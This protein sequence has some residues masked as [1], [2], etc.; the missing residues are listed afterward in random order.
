MVIMHSMMTLV[1]SNMW[2]AVCLC[3]SAA[4][5]A[6]AGTEQ[7]TP[8]SARQAGAQRAGSFSLTVG[9]VAPQPVCGWHAIDVAGKA[10][11]S[12]QHPLPASPTA[13]AVPCQAHRS[14]QTGATAGPGWIQ[15]S[16]SA[17]PLAQP[18]PTAGQRRKRARW[19]S[20]SHLWHLQVVPI[21][22]WAVQ[23]SPLHQQAGQAQ[24]HPGVVVHSVCIAALP[25]PPT[26]PPR[27]TSVA[28]CTCLPPNLPS[29]QQGSVCPFGRCQPW[30]LGTSGQG[31]GW[32]CSARRSP[33]PWTRCRP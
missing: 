3:C 6:A 22:R 17:L 33:Q 2:A 13:T 1:R 26:P 15:R 16:T 9:V 8:S 21:Q 14:T 24:A 31:T 4:A 30:A 18:P 5:G 10:S 29:R 7:A 27:H 28:Y 12:L 25:F 11:K 19:Q 23:D 32:L 20:V